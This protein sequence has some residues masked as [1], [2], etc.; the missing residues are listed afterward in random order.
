MQAV[1]S[2][3][4]HSLK[5]FDFVYTPEDPEPY[6][7]YFAMAVQSGLWSGCAVGCECGHAAIGRWKD[8]LDELYRFKRE[9]AALDAGY[10][11]SLLLRMN[12]TGHLTVSGTLMDHQGENRMVFSFEADQTVLKDFIGQLKKMT[13]EKH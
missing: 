9:E 4:G 3:G 2:F 10:G 5:I 6:N 8:A 11:N 7:C 13:G 12:H 1:L